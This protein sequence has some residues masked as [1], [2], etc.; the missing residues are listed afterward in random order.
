M[1]EIEG[2]LTTADGTFAVTIRRE[3]ATMPPKR[4]TTYPKTTRDQLLRLQ[5]HRCAI[6]RGPL[7][8][9][10]SHIDHIMPVALGGSD[11]FSNLQL[12]HAHCNLRK[13]ARVDD[14]DQ[15]RMPWA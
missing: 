4:R 5:N 2:L 12:T 14:S 9:Y 11:E 7:S 15:E 13:G 10:E 8:F 6:C 3:V 1:D